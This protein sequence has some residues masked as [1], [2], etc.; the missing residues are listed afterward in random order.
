MLP[1]TLLSPS[2][3]QRVADSR[4]GCCSWCSSPLLFSCYCV[5][6]AG[7]PVHPSAEFL[8]AGGRGDAAPS[9]YFND[10]AGNLLEIAERD[11][12]PE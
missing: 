4:G 3:R 11:L 1:W 10:P 5:G 8:G 7:R 9:C 12:W 2:S 6:A